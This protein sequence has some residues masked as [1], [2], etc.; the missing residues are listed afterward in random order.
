MR[1]NLTSTYTRCRPPIYYCV[2]IKNGEEINLSSDTTVT[3]L[4]FSGQ[5]DPILTFDKLSIGDAFTLYSVDRRV[6]IKVGTISWVSLAG[7]TIRLID[8]NTEVKRVDMAIQVGDIS[9]IGVLKDRG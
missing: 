2:N 9:T 4:I 8:E 1:A 6:F 5:P 3:K 7:S